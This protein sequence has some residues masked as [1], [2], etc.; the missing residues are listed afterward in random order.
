VEDVETQAQMTALIQTGELDNADLIIGPF[1]S[2]EFSVLCQYAKGKNMLLV[3]PFSSTSESHGAMVYKATTNAY[4]GESFANYILQKHPNANVLFV[5]YQSSQENKKIADYRSAMQKVF[6]QAGKNINIQEVN[7]KN[8]DLSGIKSAL[9][10]MKENFLFAFFEGELT[11][12]NFTQNLYAAK[13]G[14]LSLIA[15]EIW[16]RYDNIETEYFMSLNTHYISPYFVDYSNPKVI[17]FIDAFRNA[18]YTE[19]TVE[20]HAFQGYDVT[21]Y[22]LN[23]LCETGTSFQAFDNNDNLLSTKFKFAPSSAEKNVMENTFAHV[24]KIKNYK[25]INAFSD[26]EPNAPKNTP[27]PNK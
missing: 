8:T 27:K 3:D 7:I 9:S 24:F 1:Q 6:N 4:M 26:N 13:I 5:N 16:L 17:R 14:N 15:P 18:Y 12:T 23:K 20:L 10:N 22:F 25:F 2:K 19:P 11:V 21:Y